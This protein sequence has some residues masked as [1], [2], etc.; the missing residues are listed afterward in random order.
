VLTVIAL[1]SVALA[2]TL[3][4]RWA[5]RRVDSL[6]RPRPFP[7]VS[8]GVVLL[9]AL[10]TGVPA[11]LHLRM[12]RRL[13]E[14]ASGLVG[15]SVT[16]Q[17]KTLGQSWLD[18]HTELG[19]VRFSADGVPEP[20]TVLADEA[21]QDLEAWRR[22][23]HEVLDRDQVIAVHVLTHESMHMTGIANEA[24]TECAAM[25]RDVR[26]AQALGATEAQGIELARFYWEQVYPQVPDEYWSNEC[27]PGGEL[28]ESLPNAPWS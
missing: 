7:T 10:A 8:I 24:R 6:G 5:V 23:D 12:E 22:S 18:A 27:A 21:C 17:C 26:T 2:L 14:V 9:V 16:V 28:D 4:L 25:Q 3:V 15:S 11:I 19:Y 20:E 13:S 1:I